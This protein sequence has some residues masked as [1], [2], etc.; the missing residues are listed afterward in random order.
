MK[1]VLLLCLLW[2]CACLLTGC[3]ASPS[4]PKATLSVMATR[5]IA[6]SSNPTATPPSIPPSPSATAQTTAISKRL[7]GCNATEETK[8]LLS[9]TSARQPTLTALPNTPLTARAGFSIASPADPVYWSTQLGARWYL[10]W[11]VH[12]TPPAAAE[13]VHWQMVRL[14][15][16]CIQPGL[17]DIGRIAAQFPGQVWVIGNEPDVKVQDNT[18]AA[19]YAHLYHDLYAA[20]KAADPTAQVAVGGVSQASALRLRYLDEVLQKYRQS[21]QTS[22]PADWWTVHGYVLRE[23]RGSWGVDIPPG[24]PE[25]QGKLYE[26]EDHGRLD[27]F[28][29]QLIAFRKW[30]AENG[31]ASTPLA[32]TEF[33]ILMPADYGFPP[34]VIAQYMKDT[35]HWL[36]TA[37]DGV[38]GYPPDQYHLI[39]KWAWF[40]LSDTQFTVA[41]LGDLTT[42][43]LTPLGETFR[44]LQAEP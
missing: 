2:I 19:D 30:M 31:Y 13:P 18:S 43:K 38:L 34:E 23:E 20:I 10:D 11:R 29:A 42:G 22:L 39:Q 12:A 4:T 44:S 33:G 6:G 8:S 40:S 37:Q 27:L 5:S 41:N 24:M 36:A 17:P 3:G 14:F 32:L 26:V 21:Y 25:T 15:P 9:T 28:Q 16:T 35:T 1:R 7:A